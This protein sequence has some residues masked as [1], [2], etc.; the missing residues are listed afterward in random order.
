M[1]A[2]A[3]IRTSAAFSTWANRASLREVLWSSRTSDAARWPQPT[4]QAIDP[5]A[6]RRVVVQAGPGQGQAL[7]GPGVGVVPEAVVV[8]PAGCTAIAA[9]LQGQRVVAEEVVV[10]PP[11]RV[12]VV[13]LDGR[14]DDRVA[15]R[16]HGGGVV[17][18]ALHDETAHLHVVGRDAQHRGLG[19]VRRPEDR[20]DGGV[21]VG[22]V[23]AG[24][25]GH[26]V[27][28]ALD[29]ERLVD[30]DP[31]GVRAGAD[32]YPVTGGGRR[33]RRADGREVRVAALR[34]VVVDDVDVR[35]RRGHL[36]GGRQGEQGACQRQGE[37]SSHGQP[38]ES[39]RPARSGLPR[40]PESRRT[41]LVPFGRRGPSSVDRTGS[42]PKCPVRA[43]RCGPGGV[44]R[45]R[46]TPRRPRR[47]PRAAARRWS[48][49]GAGTGTRCPRCRR[50]G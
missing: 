44:S 20:Y 11:A 34:T 42:G 17:A 15:G 41:T 14:L 46:P 2:F 1:T 8:D 9:E 19:G 25:P 48:P 43:V 47:R 40:V 24:E 50:S 5:G 16:D 10:D 23:L 4:S 18:D 7:V 27:R 39:R 31:L 21:D 38:S 29:R 37:E 33:H 49:A 22:G 32:P 13:R 30:Q 6:E 26:V 28:T 3:S 36:D 12:R 35:P 45:W